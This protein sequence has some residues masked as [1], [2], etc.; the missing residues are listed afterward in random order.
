MSQAHLDEA[1]EIMTVLAELLERRPECRVEASL[2]WMAHR[3]FLRGTEL[4]E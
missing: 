3:A 4:D 2:A 1:F